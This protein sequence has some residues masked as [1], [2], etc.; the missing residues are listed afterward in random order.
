MTATVHLPD[1]MGFGWDD[2][3]VWLPKHYYPTRNDA[4]TWL[5]N[6]IGVP[7]IEVS[8]LSRW[9]VHDPQPH[10]SEWWAECPK[11]T[12]GAFPVWRCE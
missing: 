4:R 3:P 5:A 7:W 1:A 11:D 6:F 2:G 12:P 9:A 10:E 8:V